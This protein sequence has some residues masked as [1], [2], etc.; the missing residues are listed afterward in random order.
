MTSFS[1][2]KRYDVIV[3]LFSAIGYVTTLANV[4]RTLDRFHAHLADDGLVLLEPWFAPGVLTDGRVSIK[5]VES[6]GVSVARMARVTVDAR[7]SH[8]EFEY[9]IGRS[10]GIE[11]ASEVHELGLFTTEETME[12]FERA[13]FH[14]TH[15][16][17]GPYGRGL[18]IAR[19]AS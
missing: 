3:C 1:L 14:A 9:M 4:Q 17:K 10:S 5:T 18:F 7:L 8:L 16:P 2:G 11:R 12:C 19:P 6:P 15:D 13:G